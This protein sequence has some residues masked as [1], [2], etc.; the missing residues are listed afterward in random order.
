M[1]KINYV[2]ENSS[3]N[4]LDVT[5]YKGLHNGEETDFVRIAVPGDSTI[6]IDTI[7]ED[8]HKARF[9]R[10]W[11]A[12]ASLKEMTGSPIEDWDEIPAGLKKELQYQGFRF[13]EQLA[14]A[15]DSALARTMGGTTLRAKAQAFVQKSKVSSDAIIKQQ[16]D[17]IQELQEKMSILMEALNEKPKRGRP[18]ATTEE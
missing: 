9:K 14:I 18:P 8:Y 15:P 12:Y 13:V 3:D 11:D 4:Y 17:Q 7:A 10:Q 16:Q 5:F 2:G 6:E 1:E